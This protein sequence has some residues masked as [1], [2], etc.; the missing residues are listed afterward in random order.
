MKLYTKILLAMVLGALVGGLVNW[1]AAAQGMPEL[2]SIVTTYIKPFGTLFIRLIKLVAAPL[3]LAS[4]IVGAASIS[5]PA[6]LGRIG[7]KTIGLYLATTAVAITI[8]LVVVNLIRPG[9][10]LPA[11]VSAQLLAS[12]G[13]A[14]TARVST[15]EQ[16]S[17]IDSLL[18]I[19]PDNP[20]A[21]MAQ[22]EM[23][24]LVFFALLVGFALTLI[25]REKAQPVL[26]FF[27]GL[28]DVVIKIVELVMILAPIGVFALIASVVAEFGFSILATLGWYALAVILGLLLHTFGVYALMLRLFS[29]MP[30]KHFYRSLVPVHMV[31]FSSSSSAAT[32]PVNM[33]VAE[34]QLGISEEIT[35]F[36]LPL[37]ATINMDGTALYQGVA[38]VFIA[39]VY[40]IPLTLLDQVT[41]VLT[42]TL[43]SI[44]T[45]AVPGVGMIM[46]VIVL[47]SI[48]VPTEGIALI[49]GIDRV[50]DMCRTVTNVTGDAAVAVI[51][52]HSE[53]ELT[54]YDEIVR[55]QAERDAH[56]ADPRLA[57]E[58]TKDVSV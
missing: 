18:R 20:F 58:V 15:A 42:A 44:G 13:S 14:A 16:V 36:V 23:L 11:N 52:A 53:G 1:V 55:R 46:L 8:G 31:A 25:P 26:A 50:L 54:P 4:L 21:A 35:S 51:V 6:K 30:L 32:L 56:S 37:G 48:H 17:M 9:I 7:G 47:K 19:V 12:Y 43:A 10:G 34:E 2:V 39:Q 57:Q 28:T 49:F 24:Q 45:A 33:R 29:K 3:V 38:A 40:G 41:I 5:D 27:D 22:G